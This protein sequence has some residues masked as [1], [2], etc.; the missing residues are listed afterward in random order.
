MRNSVLEMRRQLFR[1]VLLVFAIGVVALTVYY[2]ADLEHA[3]E[4]TSRIFT[5]VWTI[6]YFAVIAVQ[7]RRIRQARSSGRPPTRRGRPGA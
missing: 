6:A 1:M 2:A 7:L 3:S 4:R 5:L